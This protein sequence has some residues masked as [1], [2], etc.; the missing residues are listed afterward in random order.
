MPRGS[1]ER[2][3][4][5]WT[6]RGF[7]TGVLLTAALRSQERVAQAQEEKSKA[8]IEKICVSCHDMDSA[9]AERRTRI[10]WEQ[11]VAEMV[12]RGEKPDCLQPIVKTATVSV[13]LRR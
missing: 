2:L 1:V 9:T 4:F 10:G 13:R 7:V 11:S 12:S 6:F 3:S 8:L 5:S